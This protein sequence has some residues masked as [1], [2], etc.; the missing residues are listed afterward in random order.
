MARNTARSSAP[1][2]LPP[3]FWVVLVVLVVEAVALPWLAGAVVIGA[4]ALA[5]VVLTARGRG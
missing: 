4:L 3:L 5:F 1:G 2:Q